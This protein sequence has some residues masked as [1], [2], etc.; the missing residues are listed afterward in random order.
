MEIPNTTA[1]NLAYTRRKEK[2]KKIN[3]F[4]VVCFANVPT[5]IIT[6]FL[7]LG[8]MIYLNRTLVVP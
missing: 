7:S 2:K 3:F 4:D 6:L 5:G 1:V 8:W